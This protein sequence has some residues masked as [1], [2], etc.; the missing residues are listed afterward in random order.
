[1]S[2]TTKILSGERMTIP[3]DSPVVLAE[4]MKACWKQEPSERPNFAEIIKIIKDSVGSISNLEESDSDS[5]DD[6]RAESYYQKKP[7]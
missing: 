3:T 6:N 4:L 5:D 7:L 2:A 1:M